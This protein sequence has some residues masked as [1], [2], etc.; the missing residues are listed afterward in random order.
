MREYR[1]T[2]KWK[3][4]KEKYKQSEKAKIHSKNAESK[5][6]RKIQKKVRDAAR[7][8]IFEI[9]KRL[10]PDELKTILILQK[11]CVACSAE[12]NLTIDH[13]IPISKG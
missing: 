2:E 11:K 9:K 7:R 8:S 4:W 10:S 6:E 12:E 3:Q 5:P 13:I 1:K